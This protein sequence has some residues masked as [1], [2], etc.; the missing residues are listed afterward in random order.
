MTLVP[1]AEEV[2]S[3]LNNPTHKN[4]N[5]S[6][7]NQRGGPSSATVAFS[8]TPNLNIFFGTSDSSRKF[9][10]LHN[11][12]RVAFH[13]TDEVRRFTVQIEG[14]ATEL[15]KAGMQPFEDTHYRKLG[16]SS[17]RFKL[18]PDQHF[19]AIW[20]TWL[21]FSDCIENPWTTTV[22]IGGES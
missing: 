13:V 8:A 21:R 17:K 11:D 4:G 3:F 14:V 15:S 16:D 6:Y 2:I 18:L 12:K 22:L 20:T 9:R 19:F 7:L 5:L 1:T 10:L